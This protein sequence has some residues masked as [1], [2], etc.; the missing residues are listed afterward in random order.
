[1][2]CFYHEKKA[3]T[4]PD[5][6]LTLGGFEANGQLFFLG[7]LVSIVCQHGP[8]PGPVTASTGD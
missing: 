6:A 3:N 8:H 2:T 7:L 4:W 5:I 1:M